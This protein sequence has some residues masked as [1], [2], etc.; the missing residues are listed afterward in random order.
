MT[1]TQAYTL[2]DLDDAR[3]AFEQAVA[4]RNNHDRANPKK[5]DSLVN[6]ATLEVRKITR[7]LKRDG[8]LALTDQEQLERDLDQG[9]PKAR[10]RDVVDHEG[11]RYVRRIIPAVTSLSG[12]TVYDWDRHWLEVD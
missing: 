6:E 12:K 7:A 8:V 11:R 4:K 10:N 2:K 9:F 3:S 5:F 1:D